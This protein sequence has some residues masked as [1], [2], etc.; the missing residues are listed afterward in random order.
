MASDLRRAEREAEAA[1]DAVPHRESQLGEL[2]VP[3]D[4]VTLPGIHLR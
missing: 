2:G 3:V 4:N 1:G